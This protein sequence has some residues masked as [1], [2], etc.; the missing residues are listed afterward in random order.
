MGSALRPKVTGYKN[1]TDNQARARDIVGIGGERLFAE[2]VTR[3]RFLAE[4]SA[5]LYARLALE[6]QVLGVGVCRWRPFETG[7]LGLGELNVH[8]ARQTGDDLVL[9]LQQIGAGGVE[10][11]GP[12]MRAAVGVDELGVDPDL[13]AAGQHRAFQ[14]IAHAQIL[15][16][17]LGVDRLALE[18]EGRI[19]RD[20]EA[21]ADARESGGQFIGEGVGEVI[22][23]RIAAEIGE[24]QHDN[25]K[26]LSGE[27]RRRVRGDGRRPVRVEEPPCACRDDDE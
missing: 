10:L 13:I 18:G 26:T 8:R 27:R 9:H 16:D 6:S 23:R 17:R 14:H 21:V 4:I 24:R 19:A 11:I 12:E 1:L 3:V 22:L 15:A 2:T 7:G 20:D 5:F 25:G